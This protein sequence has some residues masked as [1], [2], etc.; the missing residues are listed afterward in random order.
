MSASTEQNNGSHEILQ[1]T[2]ELVRITE[3]VKNSM[4][5]QKNATEEFNKSLR[6]LRD[7]SLQNKG[8]VKSH[9]DNLT[10]LISSL[11]QMKS[12]IEDN[13]EHAGIL[14]NLVEKFILEDKGR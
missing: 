2:Q 10:A 14:H 8:N 12:I 11:E 5:E 6:D 7:L 3:D 13:Q 9:V 1:S 4:V